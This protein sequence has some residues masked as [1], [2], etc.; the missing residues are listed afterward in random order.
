METK[1]K[2]LIDEETLEK[3]FHL[4]GKL[5]GHYRLKAR[6]AEIERRNG[7]VQREAKYKAKAAEV[8]EILVAVAEA[9]EDEA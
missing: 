3:A 1:A 6:K 4:L 7:C 8:N 5:E 9:L 2:I